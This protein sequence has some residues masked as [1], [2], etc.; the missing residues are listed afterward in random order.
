MEKQT[1]GGF[2]ATLRKANGYTQQEIAEKIGVSNKT[3]SSWETDKTCPDLTLIPVLADLYGV[4]SDE[5][6]RA[7]RRRSETA[8][9][10]RTPAERAAGNE[11]NIRVILKRQSRSFRNRNYILRGVSVAVWILLAAA[12]L[13]WLYVNMA[14]A[15]VF[16]V[17]FAAGMVTLSILL[18]VFSDN[19]LSFV[20]DSGENGGKIEN[21]TAY[22]SDVYRER[23]R[24]IAVLVFPVFAGALVFPIY[25]C[26]KWVA[27]GVDAVSEPFA[28]LAVLG[29]W[30]AA[31]VAFLVYRAYRK[32][33]EKYFLSEREKNSFLF[34][35]KL[36]KKCLRSS[37][38]ASGSL[39]V[40]FVIVSVF[41]SIFI[42]RDELYSAE[43]EDF[44]RYVQTVELSTSF[45]DMPTGEYYFDIENAVKEMRENGEKKEIEL[46]NDFFLIGTVSKRNSRDG[47]MTYEGLSLCWKDG[48]I[49]TH[50]IVNNIVYSEKAD[51][52]LL[53]YASYVPSELYVRE[54][55]GIYTIGTQT[56]L[57]RGM[58]IV[59][60]FLEFLPVPICFSVYCIKRKK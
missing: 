32:R 14:A 9:K 7:E 17:L 11:K 48:N 36:L 3:L 2:L 29:L 23:W 58:K 49:T 15:I 30:I 1:I 47:I 39:A 53:R 54:K 8:E 45:S 21:V 12:V 5:I 33:I 56:T 43:K 26:G 20:A 4:T 10:E 59:I 22:K 41:P 60:C 35:G 34:N 46:G 25:C 40:L 57:A 42:W 18:H 16:A 28:L 31:I 38:C 52:F 37:A 6:L 24:T 44:R 51:A 27:R 50:Y 19:A 13:F 55:K